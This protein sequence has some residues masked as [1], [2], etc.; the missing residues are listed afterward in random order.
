MGKGCGLAARSGGLR[1]FKKRPLLGAC[2][3]G[4]LYKAIYFILCVKKQFQVRHITG[5]ACHFEEKKLKAYPGIIRT[6]LTG[7]STYV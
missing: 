4:G 2:F 7:K 3:E 6:H 1:P 5:R